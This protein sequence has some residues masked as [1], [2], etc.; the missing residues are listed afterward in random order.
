ME[1]TKEYLSKGILMRKKV[2]DAYFGFFKLT[3]A[4]YE[5]EKAFSV[6]EIFEFNSLGFDVIEV[7]SVAL[8]LI[9]NICRDL[10]VK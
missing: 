1:E 7:D 4:E 9:L 10:G 2:K 3:P 6:D 8:S 5:Y